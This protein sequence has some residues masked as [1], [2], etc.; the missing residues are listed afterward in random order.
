MAEITKTTAKI[1]TTYSDRA[2]IVQHKT[3]VAITAGQAVTLNT[4]GKL[5]LADANDSDADH[6]LGIALET[7]G[8]GQVC[9]VCVRGHIYGFDVASK[10]A[11]STVFVSDDAGKLADAA[12]T[13]AVIAGYVSALADA[14]KVLY[15]RGFPALDDWIIATFA[16]IT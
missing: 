4:A 7:V 3:A 2:E 11:M 15:V 10:N 8:I 14:T 13:K 16:P 1:A 5:V 9:A 6:F 12:G